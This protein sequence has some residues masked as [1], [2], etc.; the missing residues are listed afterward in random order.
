MIEE[1]KNIKSDKVTL[2]KF[3]VLIGSIL[4]LIGAVMW[5][6]EN[7][8]YSWFAGIGLFIVILAVIYPKILLPLH[9]AWM[10]IALLL[11]WVMSRVLLTVLYFIVV[12]PVGVVSRLFGKHHLDLN[13]ND[14]Q[15]SYW[16]RKE[17]KD[18][19]NRIHERQF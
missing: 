9:K 6:K 15:E 17:N 12:T 14:P 11:G 7:V 10:T 8:F 4:V 13:W 16:N 1:I 2:K 19:D 3:G 5:W 18:Y